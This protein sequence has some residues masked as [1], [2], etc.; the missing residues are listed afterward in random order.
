MQ[1]YTGDQPFIFVSYAHSDS[2]IVFPI[3]EILQNNVKVPGTF[4]DKH[5]HHSSRIL[6]QVDQQLFLRVLLKGSS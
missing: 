3:I 4:T 1:A 5:M 6:I 2:N